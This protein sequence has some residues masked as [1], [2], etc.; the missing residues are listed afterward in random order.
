VGF[1]QLGDDGLRHLGVVQVLGALLALG[2]GEHHWFL[3]SKFGGDLS[4]KAL[5]IKYKKR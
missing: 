2:W 5:K 1:S 3:V 4:Q